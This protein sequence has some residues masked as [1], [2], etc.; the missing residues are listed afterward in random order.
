MQANRGGS[1][2]K[3]QLIFLLILALVFS[4]SNFSYA[5]NDLNLTAESAI[6][7]DSE[8]GDILFE[9][10]SNK[11]MFP[12]STTKILTAIIAIEN[13]DLE[14]K[15]VIDE[16][17]AQSAEGTH[18]G[19][20]AGEALTM[21]DLIHA[22]LISS[23]NDSAVAIAK[24]VSGNVSDFSSLMNK[25]AIRMGAKDSNFTNPNGLPDENH[26]STAY[27]LSM[28]AK[29]AM[30]ND[31]F[32]EIVKKSIYTIQPTNKSE[33][34]KLKNSNKMLYSDL[35]IDVDGK[36]VPIKYEGVEGIKTGYTK[37][38]G[39]CLVS[40]VK[41]T[42]GDFISVVL[43]SV[44]KNIYADTHKLLN[45]ANKNTKIVIAKRN[46]FIDNIDITGGEPN[47]LTAVFK[48]DFALNQTGE[49][50]DDIKKEFTLNPLKPPVK[51][52]E[53]IGKVS[54]K[55]KFETLGT[56]DIISD[57]QVV[58]ASKNISGVLENIAHKWWFWVLVSFIVLRV[59]VAIRNVTYRTLR[60]R[61]ARKNKQ[62]ARNLRK[63]R[64]TD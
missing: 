2:L 52:G 64:Q 44:S 39:Q 60:L 23:A 38:A 1:V 25:E 37:A 6:L 5:D 54:F 36:S 31:V 50:L 34:R 47:S 62:K 41:K 10:E 14:Q 21:N 48:A 55:N 63:K 4:M 15:I 12:A 28:I 18:I 24:A 33:E 40:S 42:D 26:V 43:K 7:I 29:Y 49:D 57:T 35:K 17:T 32:R 59:T 8:N 51:R 45:Y 46:E 13:S 53:V 11:I 19:L 3:K 30:K 20:I 56:V 22:L 16:E 27:D 9:K 58:Q 61:K